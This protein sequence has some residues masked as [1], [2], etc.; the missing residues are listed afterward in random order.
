MDFFINK[1]A[2]LPNLV[3][4]LIQ[5]GRN[6]YKEFNELIQNANITFS[7]VDIETGVR[8]ISKRP[9]SCELKSLPT[10]TSEEYYIIYKW[11]EKDTN[12]AGTYRAYFEFEFLDGSGFLICPIRDQLNVH[13][14]G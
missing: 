7:M 9:A 8:K 6:D 3:T 11:S 14:R 12:K 1:H 13:I 5:D 10:D 4:E 2:T